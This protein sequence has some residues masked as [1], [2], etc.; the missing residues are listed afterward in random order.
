M[1]RGKGEGSISDAPN[2]KGYWVG[3]LELP[4]HE[5][6]E[7]GTPKRR[8]KTLYNRNKAELIRE[9]NRMRKALEDS[10]D[11]PTAS[12]SVAKWMTHWLSDIAPKQL[13]PS[14]LPSYRSITT[15]HI[16]PAIGSVRLDKLKPNDVRRVIQRMVANGLSPNYLRNAF[17]VMSSAFKVAEREGL[18]S[19]NPC[20]LMDTPRK[21]RAQLEVLTAAEA[22]RVLRSFSGSPEAIIWA[23]FML[24]GARR[25]EVLGLEWDRIGDRE[26]DLS[27]QLQRILWAHGCGTRPKKGEAGVCGYRRAAS[28]PTKRIEIPNDYEVRHITGGLY[29]TRPKSNAGWRI[30]PLVEPLRTWLQQWR[31]QAPS[32]PHGLVFVNPDGTPFDPA[33]AS[34][35]WR[36][37]RAGVGID[38]DIRL[39]DLRHGA[40][41]LMYE[42]K[43]READ[44]IRIF[45]HSTVQMSRSYR[46]GGNRESEYEAMTAL[47]EAYGYPA[48]TG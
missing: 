3:R 8:R 4:S 23:T 13:R 48:I 7:D 22:T 9:M 33:D 26:I 46:S 18:I 24:T 28:C 27:W 29:F 41:D 36:D 20:D 25:G 32:N 15:R 6:N 47:S 39:H 42:K 30:V 40:I 31:S 37:V 43:V 2:S 16:V 38:R 19:R 10:G 44:I 17:A 35:V 34:R 14:A 21:G 11:M 5:L 12:Q 45:G 1:A